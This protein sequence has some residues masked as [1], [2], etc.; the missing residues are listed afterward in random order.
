MKFEVQLPYEEEIFTPG[1]ICCAVGS[2]KSRATGS[3]AAEELLDEDLHPD[4][5]T[6]PA[7]ANTRQYELTIRHHRKRICTD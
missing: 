1:R 6:T 7:S 2:P 5:N 4:N 3:A